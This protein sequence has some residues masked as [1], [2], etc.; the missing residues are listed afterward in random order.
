MEERELDL[1]PHA[2]ALKLQA[3]YG[4]LKTAERKAA[5]YLLAFPGG[6]PE[7]TIV[8]YADRAGCSEATI[9]RLSKRLGYEGY[10]ELKAAFA[11]AFSAGGLADGLL[12][13]RGLKA[14]DEPEAA[15]RKVFDATAQAI[16][17]TA[18][19]IDA[20]AYRRALEALCSAPSIMFSGVGDA[21]VVAQEAY[22]RWLRVGQRSLFSADHDIQ[23]ILASK[24]KPG[25]AL[26][27]VSHSGQTR[28]LLAIVR[29]AEKAG[30][31]VIALTNYPLSA[32]AK[33]SSCVLQTAVFTPYVSGEVMSK[34]VAE[35]CIIES[36]FVNFI[37]R[38]GDSFLSNL[39][40]SNEVVKQ[41]KL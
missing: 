5:D 25:D 23:L 28:S 3:V 29:E 18:A 22:F 38:K 20:G 2:C 37:M 21:S 10:P 11:A 35:L 34:R 1:I 13:Y 6:I 7:L 16:R 41:N 24:L 39:A 12:E 30:A 19:V 27:A 8:D 26:L 9:V 4:T 32:L 15:M 36:L 17:D 14:D 31:T 33:R 40:A